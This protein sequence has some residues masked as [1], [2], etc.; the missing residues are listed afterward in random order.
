L[1]EYVHCDLCGQDDGS[2]LHCGSERGWTPNRPLADGSAPAHCTTHLFAASD[3]VTGEW[4]DV[5][6][7]NQ[8]GLVYTNPRPTRE[9]MPRY[10]PPEYHAHHKDLLRRSVEALIRQV[11][12][13]RNREVLC[14]LPS[15]RPGRVLDIG[16]G[17]GWQLYDLRARGAEVVGTELSED[18]ARFARQELGLDVRVGLLEDVRNG[19]QWGSLP[20]P[21]FAAQSF[22]LIMAWH[23]LEHL[24]SP[25]RTLT[26][27]H[28]LLRPGGH[29]LIAVPNFDSLQARIA[30]QHWFH[31]DVPRHVYHFSR[32]TLVA[33][34]EDV[35]FRVVD[36]G[37]HAAT[38]DVCGLTQSLL[39]L[40][41]LAPNLLYGY[42]RY[43]VPREE[44]IGPSRLMWNLAVSLVLL[45][46]A[47]AV[48]VAVAGLGR[49][50]GQGASLQV[51][52]T[53]CGSPPPALTHRTSEKKKSITIP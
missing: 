19:M 37:F 14:W 8:C 4:F 27:A 32:H 48:G 1:L 17:Q 36:I 30:G 26:E 28:R 35:G 20:S 13:R 29:L 7:C 2:E 46:A 15:D 25:R 34:L 53:V 21:G 3:Y 50:L 41:G 31:L 23:A 33:L 18:A 44:T 10:Y 45:P 24:P 47:A 38:I 43:K 42:V 39:N 49:W 12:Y 52:A 9:G 22:D 51:V 40:C 16:C 6:R 11:R 5:V